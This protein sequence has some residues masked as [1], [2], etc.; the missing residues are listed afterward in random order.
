MQKYM[1]A[2]DQHLNDFIAKPMSMGSEF[3]LP[4]WKN[5]LHKKTGPGSL[6]KIILCQTESQLGICSFSWPKRFS[7]LGA[8]K[9]LNSLRIVSMKVWR[10]TGHL[11][12]IMGLQITLSNGQVS[13]TFGLFSSELEKKVKNGRLVIEELKFVKEEG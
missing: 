4:R 1:K 11:N 6:R 7:D 12:R 8:L 5:T 2:A 3:F 13:P 9:L 10:T